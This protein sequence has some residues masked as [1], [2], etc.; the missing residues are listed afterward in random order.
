MELPTTAQS[1]P[2]LGSLVA[3]PPANAAPPSTG[4]TIDMK[5][6]ANG[7]IAATES[8]V[9]CKSDNSKKQSFQSC[10]VTKLSA[11][12]MKVVLKYEC[13][14][15]EHLKHLALAYA[16]AILPKDQIASFVDL[17]CSIVGPE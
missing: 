8:Y 15:Q 11:K 2:A 4:G 13:H 12:E 7:I 16:V 9:A 6:V 1:S 14:D 10:L 17:A 3:P 5:A